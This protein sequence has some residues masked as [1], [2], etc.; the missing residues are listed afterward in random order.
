M[1][2]P[3]MPKP[4]PSY[5]IFFNS[6]EPIR[7]VWFS[8]K[9]KSSSRNIHEDGELLFTSHGSHCSFSKALSLACSC[10]S[11]LFFPLSLHVEAS[12]IR[13]SLFQDSGFCASVPGPLL[14]L[15]TKA[16]IG[17]FPL[18]IFVELYTIFP[19]FWK[20]WA[21]FRTLLFHPLLLHI[22]LFTLAIHIHKKT[23]LIP[24][25]IRVDSTPR[26]YQDILLSWCD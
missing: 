19:P 17:P 12:S 7:V 24:N 4:F 23:A 2:W 8:K 3:L 18:S 16:T 26:F 25:F 13:H 14:W 10:C 21:W 1:P 15:A 6:L 22:P 20:F 9:D 11:K 5:P